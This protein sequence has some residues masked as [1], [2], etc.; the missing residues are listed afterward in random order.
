MSGLGSSRRLISDVILW[1]Q[2]LMNRS[3]VEPPSI[4]NF[5]TYKLTMVF[6]KSVSCEAATLD[7]ILIIENNTK[8]GSCVTSYACEMP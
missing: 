1:K 4:R 8:L 2:L 3:M 7:V 5:G 6:D